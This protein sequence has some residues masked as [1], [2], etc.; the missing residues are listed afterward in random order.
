MNWV[1]PSNP[2][3]Y[4]FKQYLNDTAYD[5]QEARNAL[6]TLDEDSAYCPSD[7]EYCD[8]RSSSS[9]NGDCYLLQLIA[10]KN[11]NVFKIGRS[12]EIN[13]RL[14][15]REYQNA[16]ILY[17]VSVVDSTKCERELINRFSKEFKRVRESDT[18]SYGLEYFEGNEAHIRRLFME[19]CD[20][21]RMY[22][23]LIIDCVNCGIYFCL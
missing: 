6:A 13:K 20:K 21:Y 9:S 5:P 23:V 15:A 7:D 22:W 14:S 19:I 11:T 18:G 17:T 12:K 4:R 16:R 1:T 8:I 3:A 10:D 2:D